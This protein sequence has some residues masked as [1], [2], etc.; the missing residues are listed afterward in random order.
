M[1]HVT[2]YFTRTD[3]PLPIE[4][5]TQ[6]SQPS[7]TA[8]SPLHYLG[9]AGPARVRASKGNGARSA[10]LARRALPLLL[11][12]LA[13]FGCLC[14]SAWAGVRHQFEKEIT[15]S[16]PSVGFVHIESLTI[17]S[18][19]LWVAEQGGVDELDASSG[20]F[21]ARPI[22]SGVDDDGGLAV[23]HGPGESAVY[24][25]TSGGSEVKVFSEAGVLK[26]AWTGAGVPGGSFGARSG[27]GIAVDNSTD[28]ADEGKGDVYVTDPAQKAVYV[29]HPE[30]DGEEHYVGEI[31]GPPGE[32][33]GYPR[34]VAVDQAN[35]DVFVIDTKFG[36][37][38][39]DVFEPTMFHSY[40]FVGK[41]PSSGTLNQPFNLAV[42]SG[43]DKIYATE[44][45]GAST[46]N[47]FNS[48]GVLVGRIVGSDTPAKEIRDTY[49]LAVEPVSHD[50][51]VS[52]SGRG[53]DVFGPDIPLSEPT[54]EAASNTTPASTKLNGTVDPE[55]QSVSSCEFE[56]GTS[57]SYGQ[58]APCKPEAKALGSGTSPVPVAAEIGG[59]HPDTTYHFRLRS[60][61]TNVLPGEVNA[62]TDE[63]FTTSGPRIVSEAPATEVTAS[64]ATLS[65]IVN[66]EG[67][68]ISKCEFEYATKS[69][70]EATGLYERSVPCE[71]PNA[72][73]IG[74]G[75][76]P[77]AVHASVTGLAG[78]TT[79]RS[80]LVLSVNIPATKEV[81]AVTGAGTELTTLPV[82][83]IAGAE[84]RNVTAS[85]AELRA[86]V[87]PEGLQVSHCAFEYGT[88]TSYGQVVRCA[89]K[90]SAIGA[91]TEP[92]TVS[93]QLTELTPDTA[94]HWRLAIK[95]ANGETFSPDH[96]FVY[97]T[98]SAV[99]PDGRAYE[100]VTPV[101]KNGSLIGDVFYGAPPV[102]SDD[103]S[104]VIALDIQCFAPAASCD[105]NRGVNGEPVELTRTSAEAGRPAEWKTTA[106]A[107]PAAQFG[108]N[109]P[110]LLSA[111]EGAALFSMPTGPA[112]ED[113]WY[114]RSPAG[115]FAAIGPATP[116]G[117]SGV[118]DFSFSGTK[119]TADLSHL[120]WENEN[121]YWAFDGTRQS[122]G[123][124]PY[125]AYEYVGAGN[126]GPF[127]VG[128]A[129][130]LGKQEQISTCGTSLGGGRE[131]NWNDLSADGRIVYFT[132]EP[133]SSCPEGVKVPS[134]TPP[135][136]ELYARVDGELPGAHTV[137]ISQPDAPQTAAEN[138]PDEDCTGQEC[139]EDIKN[140]ENWRGAQFA[141]ASTDGMSVFFLDAQ[142]LTDGATQGAYDTRA[143]G[144]S[145]SGNA[146]NLY[147][148]DM[149]E[150]AGHGLIDASAPEASNESPRVQGVVATSADGSHV[151]FVARGVLTA[152]PNTQDQSARSGRD[153]LYVYERD[154]SY[155]AGHTAFVTSLPGSTQSERENW[156]E[157]FGGPKANVAPDGRFLVFESSADLTPDDTRGAGGA[158]GAQIFRYDA[159]SGE[160]LRV[161]VG[162]AG[163]DD[164][165]NA[166]AGN[167]TI[168]PAA[169]GHAGPGR[170]D[171][172][173]SDDGSYVFFQSPVGLT[174]H[175]LDDVVIGH[176]ERYTEYAQNV[177]EYHA[178]HVYLISDGHDT[179]NASTPCGIRITGSAVCLLGADTSGANVFFMTADR[180]VP[181][182]TDTQVDIYDARVCEPAAGDPCVAPEP[183]G[184]PPCL[185]EAC[186]GI[187]AVTP[188]LLA[189]GSATFDGEGNL[190]PPPP[191]PVVKAKAKALT[192]AQKLAAA[193]RQCKRTRSRSKRVVC[194]KQARHKDGAP[195]QGKAKKSSNDRR[196]AR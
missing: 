42:D 87:N 148:Y 40:R 157:D 114:S 126:R 164:D 116:P 178:G 94:Y 118:G 58:T 26:G 67:L 88:G 64:T 123:H 1:K 176:A 63:T 174:P 143:P 186:H 13:A 81:A 115:S 89:Q 23:G 119:A 70:Y 107:P 59:L 83:V 183:V 28:S 24:V 7:D 124:G 79:Y 56:Y 106:L 105:A 147:L 154:S 133:T 138:V 5:G 140:E 73:E 52:D 161:S 146:C 185:G 16:Q 72:A 171:P 82:A 49:S 104:R 165:G 44:G 57:P 21:I 43:S 168:V 109:T 10:V 6:M 184:L 97:P 152:A 180:L 125:S 29:F 132:V 134:N 90:K 39:V 173:M 113:E 84:A 172:T 12:L 55:G 150:P 22:A 60:E 92:V 112:Q 166:G 31:A 17:D 156:G 2:P 196:A 129:G 65:G 136:K 33:F 66:P 78:G 192:R 142:E 8:G 167:A 122:G 35:G 100:M 189:P 9:V 149:N 175:A 130:G 69:G 30:T 177:Y 101:Q 4:K 96:S 36:V 144:C 153:N 111:D 46:V 158:E 139:K 37:E 74:E 11:V 145:V 80:R 53:I 127:L 91:G 102:V 48:T 25:S 151:Y 103:G 160:L 71:H 3:T 190:A 68:P 38:A 155:P 62:G 51:Y 117:V 195:K 76:S 182:D 20:A 163:F 50:V 194:E 108:E 170:G 188:S 99:L 141:G 179:S 47:E 19:H 15:E 131:N 41:I 169:G 27:G 121:S 95:D 191:P 135:V 193:L 187:P 77:V 34:Y 61:N 128:V 75:A 14:G 85:S 18:G 120:V 86:T 181:A 162:E 98:T 32:P 45:F 93:A 159:A 137:A 110:W 54:T